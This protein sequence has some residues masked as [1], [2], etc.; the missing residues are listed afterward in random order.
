MAR[1][2]VGRVV[3]MALLVVVARGAAAQSSVLAGKVTNVQSGAPVAGAVVSVVTGMTIAGTT[4][5]AADGSY[6][7][8]GL[9]DGSYA[10]IARGIGFTPKRTEGVAVKGSTTFNPALTESVAQLN[11]VAVTANRGMGTQK[12]LDIPAAISVVS[13][14]SFENKP[15]PTMA[16]YL[17]N[18]PGISI[19]QGG[20]LQSNIVSRGFN[21][22][23][24]GAM[25]NLQDYRFAGVPSLRVNVP[26]LF[27]GTKD[28]IDRIEVLN[29]PASSLYGPNS[30]N[31]VVHIITKSPFQSQG[32]TL[33][34]EG[35]N[36]SLFSVGGRHAGV[37]GDKKEFGYKLSGGYFTAE[38]FKY[39]DPNEP[40]TFPSTAPTGRAGKPIQRDFGLRR[41]T[42]EGRLDWRPSDDVENILT[43]GYTQFQGIEVTTAFGAAQGKNWTY[44]N[45]QDRFKY[46]N[47]FAQIFWNGSN[48]GNENAADLNGTYYL[49]TGIPIVDKSNVLVGQLQQSMNIADWKFIGGLDYIQTQPRSEGTIFGRNEG[50]TDIHEQ[51]AYLQTQYPLAKNLEMTAAVRGDQ[52][53]RI[54]GAQFSP[55]VAFTW[56]QSENSNWRASFSRAFNS[57]ASFSFF[58]DQISNPNQAPG[59]ALRAVGNPA[60]EGWQ[61]NRTC[62]ATI[63][64]GICMRSPFVAG[65]PGTPLTSAA[66]NAFPGFV[67]QLQAIATA[68]PDA[69]FGGA[70]QKAG[71]L[72][73]LGQMMPI[74]SQLRPTPANIGSVLRIGSAAVTPA[75]V[76]D[77]GPLNA[78]FNNTWEVGYKAIIKE[79]LRLSVDAWYQL[80]GDVGAPIG[81]LNPLVFYD[82][83]TL[84]A[85]LGGQIGAALAAQGVP[86][87]TAGATAAQAAGALTPLM[88]ALP[89]GALALTNAKLANDQ[90]IIATYTAGVGTVDV[91][92]YDV[93]VDWQADDNWLLAA[94]YS[95]QGKIV[96]P[97]IGGTVNPLM[98]NS[99]KHRATATIHY[100][101]EANGFGFET[102]ARYTDTFPVNSGLLNSL[103]S[104]P[105]A[106]GVALYPGVPTQT[107]FDVSASWRLPIQPKVTWSL[108]I[109][110][111]NDQRVP[112]FVG[113]API[114]RLA[115][116]RLQWAF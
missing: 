13:S 101:D 87:A 7:I 100:N 45:F 78:S 52:N 98:S 26:A 95:N 102:G 82:P 65:G 50:A 9:V 16:T 104:P 68:L 14:E 48:S 96:F 70:A 111:I 5:A 67:S 94:S 43:A 37:F 77:V 41:A 110:N 57:P 114:G 56:K 71:F 8:T 49:R 2:I 25:L 6:R 12:E 108:S 76:K 113:T 60:K 18:V 72:G 62:D 64:T 36:Q 46:K 29:G 22:A 11:R 3:A 42:G 73:L 66:A 30:A 40:A 55:R 90:S 107:L 83:A 28:D 17:A 109:Q 103:G 31:G 4:T 32:T 35:G 59:F 97:E 51:G 84:G 93:A 54:A 1:S 27:T 89:Q 86:A 69:S 44:S 106:A 81:Q 19:S 33:N 34:V 63:N 53:D 112:T 115:I 79:R 38:D 88:A 75:S 10:V 85:Y 20:I 116:T 39:N 105:N 61:F 47:T 92:G 99:P 80:R 23:F 58:L 15:A 21:N 74:L 24:S 91:R